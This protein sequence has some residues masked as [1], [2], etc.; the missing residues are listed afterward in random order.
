M[1]KDSNVNIVFFIRSKRTFPINKK[2][3]KF[4]RLA[5]LPERGKC[6]QSCIKVF[7]SAPSSSFR[8]IKLSLS[9]TF[10]FFLVFEKKCVKIQ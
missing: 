8:N 6:D 3:V 1:N 2:I 4:M 7:T 5:L 10:S 9:I